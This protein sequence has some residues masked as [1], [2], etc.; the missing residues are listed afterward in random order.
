MKFK[1]INK[2][3]EELIFDSIIQIIA[4]YFIIRLMILHIS[5][6]MLIIGIIVLYFVIQIPLD[7]IKKIIK[8]ETQTS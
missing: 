6:Y 3:S 7:N 5:W 4:V 8:N 1:H 2:K